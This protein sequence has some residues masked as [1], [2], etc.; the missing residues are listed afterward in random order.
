MF[1][2]ASSLSH[3]RGVGEYA[4]TSGGQVSSAVTGLY[5]WLGY[6]AAERV[7]VWGVAGYGVGDMLLT[8]EGAPAMQSGLSMAWPPPE[9]EATWSPAR[10]GSSWRSRPMRCGSARQSTG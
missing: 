3:S 1:P 5:P 4:G 2:G 7:T 6:K 9:S 10:P 8:P